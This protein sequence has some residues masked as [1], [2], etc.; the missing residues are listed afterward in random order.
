[1]GLGGAGHL[2]LGLAAVTLLRLAL[3]ALAVALAG[4]SALNAFTAAGVGATTG[5]AT[6]NPVVGYTVAV[7]VNAALDELQNYIA[8]TRQ[9][10]EQDVIAAAAGEMAVGETRDWKIVHDIPLFDD[11]HGQMQ[12]VRTIDTP[13]T[14]CKEVLFTVDEGRPPHLQRA[15]YDTDACHDT[16]GWKWAEA[17]PAVDRWGY[18]QHIAH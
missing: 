1:M 12:V 4:C 9:G 2:A 7:G 18:F 5:V 16:T 3:P 14:Q 11:E 13:L 8:R 10:A 15:R 6:A 17:E